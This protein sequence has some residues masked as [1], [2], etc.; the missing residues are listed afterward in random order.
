MDNI[1]KIILH[2]DVNSAFLSWS[3]VKL[4][5]EDP[6]A[7]D[8]RTI[9]SAVGGDVE[10]RHG[11]ISAKSIPAKKYGITTGEAV[12]KAMQKCP[13]LVIVQS[14]FKTYRE[15]SHKFIGILRTYSD[16]V[17]QV[18]IDEAFIDMTMPIIKMYEA[19]GN[20]DTS[21]EEALK[22]FACILAGRIKDEISQTLGFTVNVGISC[23]KLLAKMASDFEK[24]DKVHTLFP[25]EIKEKMWPLPIGELYGCGKQTSLRLTELG[26]KTIG[27]VAKTDPRLIQD[28]L[29]NKQ[30]GYIYQSCNGYGSSDVNPYEE[31]AKSY[32]NETTIKS[33]ITFENYEREMPQVLQWLCQNVARRLQRDG[34]FASTVSVSVKTD[35]FQRRSR[36]M[37]I[38]DSTNEY[39]ILLRTA[40]KLM[41]ELVLGE[42]GIFAQGYNIRLVGVGASDLDK[43]E[44]R[45]MSLFDLNTNSNKADDAA[46]A[47]K[48]RKLREMTKNIEL[49][50][51]EGIIQKGK[52]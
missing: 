15:Y 21:R 42:N 32:S 30:G 38:E 14:D 1:R 33:D 22:E 45:Q 25:D 4:L 12:V 11:I 47:E 2:V 8:L 52:I 44:Y 37:G 50:Y 31:D 20:I 19:A 26:M 5:K 7:V 24:P 18:S 43:G 35:S 23:N 48:Q 49:K 28:I 46:R 34:V 3:A 9:P 13:N 17:E 40:T 36:Q 16:A 51:G 39:A 27:D 29:G 41:G 6:T 10:S